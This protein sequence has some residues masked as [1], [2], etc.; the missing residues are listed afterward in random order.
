MARTNAASTSFF[1]GYGDLGRL[2]VG[3][4]ADAHAHPL[5]RGARGVVV[6]AVQVALQHDSDVL[7]V[8]RAQPVVEQ[9]ERRLRVRA[10]LHVEPH[11]APVVARAGEHVVHHLDA[12]P[13]VDVEP[14]R[15][16]LQAHVRVEPALA[17]AIEQVHVLPPGVARLARV[18]HALAE[19]VERGRG[20]LGVERD[21]GVERLLHR[22]AGDETRREVLREP[23]VAHELEDAL[24]VRQV[25][26]G[27]AKHTD[28]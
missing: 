23:I 18:G 11:E 5:A 8:R 22:L 26:Q 13:L 27:A 20:A 6:G 28:A 24:L 1:S 19:Q 16:E 14:H 17:D 2:L 10:R 15:G 9:V 3:A 4:L 25:E 12:Q 21:H 7:R